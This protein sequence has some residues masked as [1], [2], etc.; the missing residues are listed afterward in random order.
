M[1]KNWLTTEAYGEFVELLLAK[2]MY[3]AKHGTQ[4]MI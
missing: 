1:K 2:Q 4:I 3:L